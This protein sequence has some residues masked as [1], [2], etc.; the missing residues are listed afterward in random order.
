[1][2]IAIVGAG[3][4]GTNLLKVFQNIDNIEVKVVVDRQEDAEGI[5]YARSKKIPTESILE[6]IDKYG[7]EIIV[8]A[9]GVPAVIKT[10][11]DLYGHKTMIANAKIAELMMTVVDKQMEMTEKLNNQLSVINK[12]T[13][14]FEKQMDQMLESTQLLQGVS[15]KLI[16]ASEETRNSIEASDQMIQS[17][18]KIN[19]QIKIL[20]INANIEAAR[21]GEHG[22]GFS[23]VA[24]EVGK[25]AGSTE[26]F[27]GQISNLLKSISQENISISEEIH[28]LNTFSNKQTQISDNLSNHLKQL[29]TSI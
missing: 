5:V 17:I 20:G 14:A 7:V 4:G 18:Y 3:K 6:K 12:T 22:R 1:M 11:E 29:K 26:N 21:A 23:V 8:E 19:G 28:T 10:L 13:Q 16:T 27:A 2:K 25:L 15:K 24:S 9:T